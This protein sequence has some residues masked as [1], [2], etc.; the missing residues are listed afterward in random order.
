[1]MYRSGLLNR[2]IYDRL[3]RELEP[4]DV[5]SSRNFVRMDPAMF[6][7]VL[8]RVGSR[9]EKYDT[10]YRKSINPG[11]QKLQKLDDRDI[12]SHIT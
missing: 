8:Q 3:M 2:C 6:R 9:I 1:M 4:E 11:S 10:W 12:C 5:A 7:E